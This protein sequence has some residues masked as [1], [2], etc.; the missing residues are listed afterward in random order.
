MVAPRVSVL[1]P[2]YNGMPY[3]AQAVESILTQSFRDFEFIIVDD[4]SNDDTIMYLRSITDKRMVV[5]PL[6]EN[7][8]VTGALQEG[9]RHVK[10]KY[11]ARL[12]ADDVAKPNRLQIQVDYLENNPSIGLL[13]SSLELI[14]ADGNF[15]KHVNLTR[16]DI[17][18][19][20][21]FLVKNPFFHSTV[22]FRYDLVK[23][24][25]LGYSRKHGEDYQ[26]WVDLLK[27]CKG[28]ILRDE[29][30]QY[31]SHA[32]SW[33]YTKMAQQ[34]TAFDEI[35]GAVLEQ[36]L[37]GITSKVEIRKFVS[38]MRNPEIRNEGGTLFWDTYRLLVNAFAS[39]EVEPSARKHF[40]KNKLNL[41][42]GNSVWIRLKSLM[43][44]R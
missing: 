15:L 25:R 39:I 30:I 44:S 32:Q 23:Q 36:Y 17:E 29:L 22:M 28:A 35:N 33:T 20:W 43:K 13:G 34:Q 12:D 1:M 7:R 26:L 3:L 8:G 16:N 40:V 42:Q 4:C 38:W 9:M 24:N 21:R 37:P 19:R 10:G 31:R 27:F 14:D 41:I 6:P 18:I 5:L 2:V 11:V